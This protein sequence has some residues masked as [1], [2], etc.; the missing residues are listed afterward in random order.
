MRTVLDAS[1]LLSALLEE[2]GA[3]TVEA[4][5]ETALISTVNLAETVSALG[6]DGNPAEEV[7]AIIASLQLAAVPPDEAMAVD[8]GL[9]R[10][11][12]DAA[13]LSLGDRFCLALARRLGA[14][15]LTADRAWARVAGQAGVEIRQIR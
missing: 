9:L 2:P 6:R 12:T 5:I 11:I 4:A 10:S 14:P 1:A 8:A 3:E 15:V 7:R 13:G